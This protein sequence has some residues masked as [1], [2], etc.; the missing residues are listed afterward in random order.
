M[1]EVHFRVHFEVGQ[2]F[3]VMAPNATIARLK[4]LAARPDSY[5]KKIKIVK[6]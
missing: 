6:G 3:D 1:A 2:P 4:A 5:V